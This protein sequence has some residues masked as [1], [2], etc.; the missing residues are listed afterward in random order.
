[1]GRGP[2]SRA[3]AERNDL[4]QEATRARLARQINQFARREDGPPSDVEGEES[5]LY[6]S[7]TKG[8]SRYLK[9]PLPDAAP[10]GWYHQDLHLGCS[11]ISF[12]TSQGKKN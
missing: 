10:V 12:E 8:S 4:P 2:R 1:M 3:D 6:T 9:T 5:Y 7:G 11:T